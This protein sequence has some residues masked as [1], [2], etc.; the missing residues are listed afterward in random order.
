MN[1]IEI[2]R[3]W[4]LMVAAVTSLG[5]MGAQLNPEQAYMAG[6][7]VE[8]GP[9]GEFGIYSTVLDSNGIE[10]ESLTLEDIY[11]SYKF[12]IV[13]ISNLNPLEITPIDT[14][15]T[16]RFY[17]DAIRFVNCSTVAYLHVDSSDAGRA[18]QTFFMTRNFNKPKRTEMILKSVSEQP[19]EVL[20]LI[21]TDF[22]LIPE[23]SLLI[24]QVDQRCMISKIICD[25]YV[26]N[27]K[28]L[29]LSGFLTFTYLYEQK[30]II[31]S[32]SDTATHPIVGDSMSLVA[33]DW[34]SDTYDTL[35][36]SRAEL[37]QPALSEVDGYLYYYKLPYTDDSIGAPN[38]W[39]LDSSGLEQQVT[40]F[41][42][43]SELKRFHVLGDSL[44]C[45]L[46]PNNCL[47]DLDP[48]YEIRI[49]Q[50]P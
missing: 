5:S 2:I 4:P 30:R 34:N 9:C 33:Y 17:P 18:T 27:L 10:I 47:E 49:V 31:Y 15:E 39:R 16:T 19:F 26:V 21:S 41:D 38:V 3:L 7:L 1:V 32:Q 20:H 23:D 25:D 37:L 36:T 48:R 28:S 29:T 24:H 43:T 50:L 14:I 22:I 11:V 42:F 46:C 6:R 8:I 35:L 40:F 12:Y 44:A 45:W 13:S